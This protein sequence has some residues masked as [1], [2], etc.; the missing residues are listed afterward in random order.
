MGRVPLV[1][2]LIVVAAV[3]AMIALGVWQLR[4]LAWKEALLAQYTASSSREA[5]VP[6]P[7]DPATAQADLY[8]HSRLRCARVVSLATVSGR[9]ANGQPGWAHIVHCALAGGGE[10]SV[11]LGWAPTPTTPAWLGGE[12][13]GTI[14]PGPRLV[15]DP[16]LG[17]LSASARPDPS[18]IP[19][20]HLAYAVQWFLFAATALVIYVLALRKRL[21]GR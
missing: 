7:R 11:V 14:A 13:R 1:P 4:R 16:P 5:E 6:W 17:G 21:I 20:N 2:T 10:A 12:V 15:A 3:A 9:S 18:E 19:N 8:R